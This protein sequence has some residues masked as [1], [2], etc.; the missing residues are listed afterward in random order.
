MVMGPVPR[1]H[2][3][4]RPSAFSC[5]MSRE[6]RCVSLVLVECRSCPLAFILAKPDVKYFT[7]AGSCRF[8]GCPKSDSEFRSCASVCVR[9]MPGI[10]E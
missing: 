5:V 1:V 2:D 6:C 7:L 10:G 8:W 4:S 9:E 3:I